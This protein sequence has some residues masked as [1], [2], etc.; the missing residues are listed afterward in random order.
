LLGVTV[1]LPPLRE[2]RCDLGILVGTLLRRLDPA[3]RARLTPA[4]ARA[5]FAYAWPRN[6]RELER[7]LAGGLARTSDGMIDLEHLP[8][9]IAACIE[10]EA[11][12]AGA[13]T[14]APSVDPDDEALRAAIVDALVRN[15]GNVTAAARE[16][17]KHREQVHRWARRLGIDLNSFRH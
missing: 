8:E 14:P 11:A 15:D 5:L 3:N 1:T 6:I 9:D 7:A 16:L 4:A 10:R 17:G 13:P 2:R 12:P